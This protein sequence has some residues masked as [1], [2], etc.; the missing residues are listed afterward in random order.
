MLHQFPRRP[1][2][3]DTELI[4]REQNDRMWNRDHCIPCIHILNTV[5]RKRLR[6]LL[7]FVSR[8][9]TSRPPFKGELRWQHSNSIFRGLSCNRTASKEWYMWRHWRGHEK[10]WIIGRI[11]KFNRTNEGYLQH[12]PKIKN[13]LSVPSHWKN[14]FRIHL[15]NIHGRAF[16][17]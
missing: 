15:T 4:W 9:D 11:R 1:L 6:S 17:S 5:S 8:G 13:T 16:P 14:L 3:G 7:R 10:Q 2:A 12:D